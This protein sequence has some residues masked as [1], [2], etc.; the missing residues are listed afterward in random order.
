MRSD[1]QLDLVQF[2][3]LLE[4][5]DEVYVRMVIMKQADSWTMQWLILT[6]A[7]DLFLPEW[8][9]YDYG[10]LAFFANQLSGS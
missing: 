2:L 4:K 7:P 6:V 10:E 1:E 5:Q 8:S 3:Q 9:C